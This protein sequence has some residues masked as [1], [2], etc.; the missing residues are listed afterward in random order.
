MMTL[1]YRLLMACMLVPVLSACASS[2]AKPRQCPQVAILRPLDR[3]A[4][5]GHDVAEQGR[6]V[7][8]ALIQ[9]VEGSCAYTNSGADVNFKVFIKADKGPGLGGDHLGFPFFVS[10]VSPDNKILDKELMTANFTFADESKTALFSEDLHVFIPLSGTESAENH[11]VLVGFQLTE[12][13]MRAA[14]KTPK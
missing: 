5:H 3:V 6:L 2:D 11:R 1:S 13:Q 8:D 14:N 9:K 12:D 10:L 4:D 7:G